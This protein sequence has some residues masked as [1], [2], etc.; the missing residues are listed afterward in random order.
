MDNN[1]FDFAT[2]ELSQDAVISWILNWINYPES[3]FYKLGINM[4]KLLSK[5]NGELDSLDS[6]DTEK[7]KKVLIK[8]QVE[9]ADIVVVYKPK[10]GAKQILIIEDK[11]DTSEHD[12]QIEKYKRKIGTKDIQIK[13]GL[14]KKEDENITDIK[15]VYFKTGFF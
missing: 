8:Q 13:H 2:K 7:N 9:N 11:V 6:M 12:N 5:F 4:L 15:T 14:I 3:G 1:I 10:D